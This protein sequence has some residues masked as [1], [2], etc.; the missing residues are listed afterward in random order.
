MFQAT[1]YTELAQADCF[2]FVLEMKKKNFV[3]KRFKNYC[4]LE[5]SRNISLEIFVSF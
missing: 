2:D 1:S 4:W 3:H 5:R